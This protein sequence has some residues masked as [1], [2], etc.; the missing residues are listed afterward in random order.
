MTKTKWTLFRRLWLKLNLKLAAKNNTGLST[1]AES[2]GTD[3]RHF[4]MK[5]SSL[6]FY[7][8]PDK[9]GTVSVNSFSFISR[10]VGA[11]TWSPRGAA[12]PWWTTSQESQVWREWR[13]RFLLQAETVLQDILLICNKYGIIKKRAKDKF[14]GTSSINGLVVRKYFLNRHQNAVGPVKII[15]I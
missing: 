7:C 2:S 12:Q 3:L 9:C 14:N 5:W 6:D 13:D 8:N 1:M 11:E 15:N 10:Y 4:L